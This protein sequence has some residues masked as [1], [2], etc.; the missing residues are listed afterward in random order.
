MKY[1]IIKHIGVIF[2]KGN[3]WKKELNIV[4]WGDNDPKYDVRMWNDDHTKMGK[5]CTFTKEE[6]EALTNIVGGFKDEQ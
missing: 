6:L 5:G 2:D 3:G 1:E 4:R